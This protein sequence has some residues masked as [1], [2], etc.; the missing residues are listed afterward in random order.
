MEYVQFFCLVCFFTD[1]GIMKGN[2]IWRKTNILFWSCQGID[3]EV[4][5]VREIGNDRKHIS[6]INTEL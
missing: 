2:Q 1:F 4:R 6:M 5:K 3:I